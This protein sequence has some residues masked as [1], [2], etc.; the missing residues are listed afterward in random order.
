MTTPVS[1][2]NVSVQG[3]AALAA[4]L[5][6]DPA[7]AQEL[8]ALADAAFNGCQS[9]Q[10]VQSVTAEI[11]A[12]LANA[13]LPTSGPLVDFVNQCAAQAN[14]QIIAGGTVNLTPA[15][16]PQLNDPNLV[17]EVQML[18]N[19]AFGACT[20][21]DQVQGILQSIGAALTQAGLPT[22]SPLCNYLLQLGW[23]AN[24]RIAINGVPPGADPM[25]NPSYDPTLDPNYMS[26]SDGTSGD[27]GVGDSGW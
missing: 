9:T 10:D 6:T 27:T 16:G 21:P 11:A 12:A 22:N 13:G 5:G 1:T 23:A 3:A 8:E 20:S 2:Q 4:T 18:A 17:T 7:L 19:A 25:N 15:T 24:Q 14:Q 26:P